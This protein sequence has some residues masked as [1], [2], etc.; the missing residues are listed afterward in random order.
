MPRLETLKAS[1]AEGGVAS[2]GE[3]REARWWGACWHTR[4]T[5]WESRDT[6]WEY[7]EMEL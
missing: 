2:W 4:L 3:R 5:T 1:G 7:E 6:S